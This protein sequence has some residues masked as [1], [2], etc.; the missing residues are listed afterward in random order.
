[1]QK[2]RTLGK[3]VGRETETAGRGWG[4]FAYK[5]CF[6]LD[7]IG[8][9]KGGGEEAQHVPVREG[10]PIRPLILF[11]TEPMDPAGTATLTLIIES[12]EHRG[13]DIPLVGNNAEKMR[14]RANAPS[15]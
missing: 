9:K 1:M 2:V 4:L 10:C 5:L 3:E 6:F 14:N 8:A 11:G 13:I 12:L 7:L 15:P